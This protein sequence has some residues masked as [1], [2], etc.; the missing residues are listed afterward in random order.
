[1]IYFAFMRM[2]YF[3]CLLIAVICSSCNN[4]Y[5]K[6]EETIRVLVISRE[7]D[8]GVNVKDFKI[9]KH[10]ETKNAIKVF[11]EITDLSNKTFSDTL[12]FAATGDGFVVP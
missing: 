4:F 8:K 1:M 2:K 6:N 11:L 3:A 12:N 10:T 7:S 5:N 9:I